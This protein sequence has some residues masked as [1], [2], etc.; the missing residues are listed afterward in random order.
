MGSSSASNGYGEV[1]NPAD[2]SEVVG[3][4]PLLGAGDVDAAVDAAGKAQREW[5]ARPAVERAVVLGEAADRIA[6]VPGLDE[7]LIREQ[8]KVAWEAGFE[9]GFFEAMSTYYAGMAPALDDG[10]LVVD[11]GMGQ[12]RV[13][14]EP[15]GIVGAIT[16]WNWPFA[17]TAVKLV[18]ALLAGNA[19]VV[20][21]ASNTPL[22]V[23]RAIE[24]IADLFPSGL[25]SV[26]TGP[27]SVVGRRLLE[28]PLVRKVSLTG[29]TET[30]RDAAATAGQ[31]VK[32]LTLELG[33]NDAAL[34]LDDCDIT[35]GLCGNLVAGAFTTSGQLCFGIKRVYA[36]RARAE[37]LAEGLCAILDQYVIGNGL[38]PGTSMGPV[39]NA[40]QRDYV[41]E[42]VAD[43]EARGGATRR[44]GEMA[45]DPDRGY[46]LWPTIVTGLD[47]SARLVAEEQ[48]GPAL[49]VLA[50]DSL[51]EAIDRVNASEFGLASSI[52]TADE[53]RAVGLARRI[54]AGTTFVNNHGL[55]ALDLNG[56]FG[57]VKQSGLGRELALPGLAA[58]TEPHTVSTRHL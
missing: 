25:L 56:P 33:G 48:F 49:P 1:R 52:W 9:V 3:T 39:N 19:V 21:P 24:A 55:F 14:L 32:N 8:G 43:A 16:P 28:H 50:Y 13:F 11:D 38:E 2:T 15:V 46:F 34:V 31:T 12:V 22:V 45:G 6:A 57:G 58:Y 51:D 27:G 7:L 30:G 5:A 36:P 37:E 26:V 29:S 35:E 41:T 47:D 40:A 42:L 18:P 17:L 54:Q 23:M 20:K 44:C 4:Y 10:E 53:E